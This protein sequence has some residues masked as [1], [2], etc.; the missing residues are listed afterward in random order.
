MTPPDATSLLT[1]P[2]TCTPVIDS[3]HAPD[4]GDT[5][6]L[7]GSMAAFATTPATP[8]HFSFTVDNGSLRDTIDVALFDRVMDGS[9][10]FAWGHHGS[11]SEHLSVPSPEDMA[12]YVDPDARITRSFEVLF[13]SQVIAEGPG[14]M[15]QIS[16]SSGWIMIRVAAD[17][18]G[19]ARSVGTASL[20]RMPQPPEDVT[21]DPSEVRL[22]VWCNSGSGARTT[23]ATATAPSWEEGESNY[24]MAT[25]S[26][27]GLLVATR[28]DD[29]GR[30]GGSL[31]LF[32]GP[33]GVGKTSAVRTL[34]RE[35]ADWCDFETITDPE[36]L[37]VDPTYLVA[38]VDGKKPD[39]G[40]DPDDEGGR[41]FRC[42]VLE[43][44]DNYLHAEAGCR[45][46]AIS[47]LLNT[48]DGLV[49]N[50]RLLVLL[51]MNT[52]AHRLNPAILRPGRMFASIGFER[53]GQTE[54][55]RW[56][57]Q[58]AAIPV[59]GI[60]LAEL[61]AVRGDLGQITSE[62]ESTVGGYL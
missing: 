56:L 47:R 38:V 6:P 32:H 37:F 27:L 50:D 61:L 5:W 48:A 17:S 43:D 26:S 42:L 34:A 20:A 12:S 15:V 8:V 30:L 7:T 52:P 62:R 35:W 23:W 57:G 18:P 36:N 29:A 59:G 45:E 39:V 16:V 22:R 9:L 55:R 4:A 40:S 19:L 28:P 1:A 10:P 54:A 46:A 60:S 33:P 13:G 2:T 41:R 31:V 24:P 3:S 14:Y 58:R 25:A 44:A 53:F 51:T 49:G 11:T 21:A